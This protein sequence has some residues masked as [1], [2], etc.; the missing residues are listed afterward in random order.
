VQSSSRN[1]TQ[2]A[3]VWRLYLEHGA[4]FLRVLASLR[5]KGAQIEDD[6][7][8]EFVHQFLV[9]QAPK[10]LATFRADRGDV[11]PWLFVVFRRFVAEQL[12]KESRSEHLLWSF[13]GESPSSIH[14]TTAEDRHDAAA[15]RR[16]ID[17]LPAEQQQ[18]LWSFLRTQS[19]RN[20]ARQFSLSRWQTRRLLD[21][22]IEEVVHS[23]GSDPEKFKHQEGASWVMESFRKL[24]RRNRP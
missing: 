22:A 7:Q 17:A 2:W 15:V 3:D 23:L 8:F 5:S 20:V 12:Q 6:R 9:E 19:V 24:I 14:D 1:E 10:A 4:V 21:V 16:A 18:V 11:E 13:Q